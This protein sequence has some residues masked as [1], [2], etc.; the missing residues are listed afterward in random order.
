MLGLDERFRVDGDTECLLELVRRHH[1]RGT[2]RGQRLQVSFSLPKESRAQ[3]EL[4]DVTGRRILDLDVGSLGAGRHRVNL[5]EG[6]RVAP[7]LYWIRL[8][9]GNNRRESRLTVI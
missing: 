9:Q 1:P 2:A 5:A 7:G 6:R 8:T 4:V 3:L